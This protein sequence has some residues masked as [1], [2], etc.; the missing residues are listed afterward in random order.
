MNQD[1]E[2]DAVYLLKH[3][4]RQEIQEYFKGKQ[5]GTYPAD[6]PAYMDQMLREHKMKRKTLARRSGLSEQ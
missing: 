4:R 1:R 3:G 6:F 2:I 5:K